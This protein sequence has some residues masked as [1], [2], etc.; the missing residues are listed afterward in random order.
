M[1]TIY[2]CHN[3]NQ[4]KT[5]ENLVH[6]YIYKLMKLI[7]SDCLKRFQASEALL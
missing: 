3:I 2:Q 6:W 4:L 5:L 7:T 1:K